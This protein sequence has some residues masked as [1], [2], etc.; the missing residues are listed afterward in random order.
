MAQGGDFLIVLQADITRTSTDARDLV[1]G[2]GHS[3]VD[4]NGFD[5]DLTGGGTLRGSIVVTPGTEFVLWNTKKT[6]VEIHVHGADGAEPSKG[7]QA[8]L[9]VPEGAVATLRAASL[10]LFAQG[11]DGG[12]GS[13]GSDGS[14]T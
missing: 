12:H 2:G 10:Q 3:A 5:L 6:P 14:L 9:V 13:V 8:A 7:G 1:A 4:L 11:G